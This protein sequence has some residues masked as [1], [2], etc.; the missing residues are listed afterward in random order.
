LGGECLSIAAGAVSDFAHL[1]DIQ[2]AGKGAVGS[3][4]QSVGGGGGRSTQEIWLDTESHIDL[5][6]ELGG[7]SN[8]DGSG[9]D[10]TGRREGDVFASGWQSRGLSIQSIGGGGGDL[11]VELR[12]PGSA[13]PA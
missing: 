5:E 1:G 11:I 7:T 12:R 6:L 8:V 4:F 13:R 9:G 3:L 2:A 10:I